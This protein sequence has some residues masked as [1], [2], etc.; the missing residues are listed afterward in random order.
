MAKLAHVDR[1]SS[2]QVIDR[3]HEQRGY[4]AC[5]PIYRGSLHGRNDVLLALLHELKFDYSVSAN[6]VMRVVHGRATQR[7]RAGN[8][9]AA[10]SN[11]CCSRLRAAQSELSVPPSLPREFVKQ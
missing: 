8:L 11:A 10:S 5:G 1:S 7:V 4:R 9:C 6:A 2:A 3:K